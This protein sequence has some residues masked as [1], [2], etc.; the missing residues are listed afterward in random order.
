M[1]VRHLELL[2]AVIDA[3]SLTRGA[4]RAGISQPAMSQAMAALARSLGEPLFLRQGRQRV[5]TGRALAIA[6]ASRPVADALERVGRLRLGAPGPAPQPLRAGLAPAAGLLYG[7]RMVQALGQVANA[8]PLSILTG[9]APRML[10]QLGRGEL[11]LVI[12]PRPRG[13]QQPGLQYAVMYTSQPIIHCRGGHP[14]EKAAS[15]QE[16]A[17]AEWAVAGQAG[18]PSNVVEEAFRVRGWTPPRIKVQCADYAMLLALVA[19]TDLLCVVSH[20]SL[21]PA[22]GQRGLAS[23]NITEGLPHYEVCLFWYP[24]PLRPWRSGMAELLAALREA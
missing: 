10:E 20:A 17:H 24:P 6:Q 23:V 11:D 9:P 16:I 14:L 2:R 21:L 12:A 22:S 3:G 8:P 19:Q 5:P 15:L 4:A 13:H 7:A 18:T 1:N